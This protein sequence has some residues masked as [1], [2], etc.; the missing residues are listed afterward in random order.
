MTTHTPGFS[1]L[2]FQRQLGIKTYETA[3]QRLHKL[4]AAMVRPD[5]DRIHGDVEVDETFIGAKQPGKRGR[6][7]AGKVIVVGAVEVLERNE[8]KERVGRLRL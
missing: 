3:F 1:A 5:R 7:A 8:R 6:G 2:Q 4:R